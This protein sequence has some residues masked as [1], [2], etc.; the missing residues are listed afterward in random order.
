MEW[1]VTDLPEPLSPT[2]ARVWPGRMSKLTP[3]TACISSCSLRKATLRLSIRINGS[4]M[5]FPRVEG[6]AQGFADEYQQRQHHRQ[7]DEG[8]DAQPGRLQVGLA[9]GNQRA[10]RRRTGRQTEAQKMQRGDGD[11]PAG[12]YEG[13]EGQGG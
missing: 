3:R 11:H 13:E 9:L 2:R 5:S 12:E 4:V 8:G 1:A 10:Q 7:H 6:I